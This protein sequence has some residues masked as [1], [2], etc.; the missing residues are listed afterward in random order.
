M[1]QKS[2]CPLTAARITVRTAKKTDV[3][4][5]PKVVRKKVVAQKEQTAKVR[6]N[7]TVHIGVTKVVRTRRPDLRKRRQR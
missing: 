2:R 7:Q 3:A 5:Q 6:T 4:S 1:V